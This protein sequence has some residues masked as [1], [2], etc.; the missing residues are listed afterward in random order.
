MTT[1][2]V[3]GKCLR[4]DDLQDPSQQAGVHGLGEVADAN[5]GPSL[6]LLSPLHAFLASLNEVRLSSDIRFFMQTTDRA[7]A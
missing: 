3:S 1:I 6:S 2:L 4:P 5:R 7:I